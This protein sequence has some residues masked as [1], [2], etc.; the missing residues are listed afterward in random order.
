MKN[1]LYL[2]MATDIMLPM[3]AEPDFDNLFVINRIDDVYGTWEYQM[4]HILTILIDGSDENVMKKH[5][6]ENNDMESKAIHKLTGPCKILSNNSDEIESI[7]YLSHPDNPWKIFTLSYKEK[8]K[9]IL[10]GCWRV[11]FEYENKVRNLI[12]YTH[13]F[14]M[15]WEPEVKDIQSIF[16]NGTYIWDYLYIERPKRLISQIQTRSKLPLSIYGDQ[17]S[18]KLFPIQLHY[19]HGDTRDGRLVSKLI[20]DDFDSYKDDQGST[21]PWWNKNYSGYDCSAK[22]LK[23]G[24]SEEE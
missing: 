22:T 3:L 21:K 6:L 20:L 24:E 10:R 5:Y 19:Y 4:K 15:I 1:I 12:Y 2:G 16:W 23:E 13:S 7:E 11:S 17:H 8:G 14:Y 18:H 9:E